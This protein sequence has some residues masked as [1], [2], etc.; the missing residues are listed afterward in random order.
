MAET[1]QQERREPSGFT[2]RTSKLASVH[3]REQGWDINEEER[4][5]MAMQ[6]QK[7]DG[8]LD[9]DY[10]ARDLGDEAAETSHAKQFKNPRWKP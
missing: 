3:A 8:G 10:G 1:R 7:Y 4:T 5:R 9:F 6:K 2:L